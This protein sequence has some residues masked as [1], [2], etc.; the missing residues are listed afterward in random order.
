M[1][2]LFLV[3]RFDPLIGAFCPLDFSGLR[4]VHNIGSVQFLDGVYGVR[5]LGCYN[6]LLH[7]QVLHQYG[8]STCLLSDSF[9]APLRHHNRRTYQYLLVL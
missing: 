7:L 3:S 8:S 9:L 5:V 1:L 6:G 2:G 4:G